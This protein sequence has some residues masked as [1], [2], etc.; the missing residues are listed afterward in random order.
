MK[1][2][3]KLKKKVNKLKQYIALSPGGAEY[4]MAEKDFKNSV[5]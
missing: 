4:L 3:E 2:N 5:N 1:E